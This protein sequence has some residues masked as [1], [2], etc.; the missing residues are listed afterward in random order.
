MVKCAPLQD[1][2]ERWFRRFKSGDFDTTQ[3]GRQ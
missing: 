2:R 1:T 3:E